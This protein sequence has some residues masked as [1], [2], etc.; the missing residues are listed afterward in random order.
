MTTIAARAPGQL[1]I[2]GASNYTNIASDGTLTLV[3]NA[4]A[5]D[6][7][8]VEPTVRATGPAIPAF[9]KW[10]DN[11]SG[12]IGVF[13]YSFTDEHTTEKEIYFTAQMPHAAKAGSDLHIHVHWIPKA[14]QNPGKVK[15]GLE[16]TWVEPTGVFGNTAIITKDTTEQPSNETALVAS[17]HYITEFAT[18]TPGAT[19]DG[20]SAILICRLFRNSTDTTNDTYTDKV[21]LLSIDIHYEADS[22]GSAQEYVK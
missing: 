11:G 9:E 22:F 15:W 3:G 6:D 2:G 19:Q 4:T 7:L 5:F 21:G 8:R 13:L 16:F 18:Q 12:S 20:L 17:K 10:F 14:S 1:R